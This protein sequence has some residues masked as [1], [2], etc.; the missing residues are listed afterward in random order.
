MNPFTI[1]HSGAGD[2]EQIREIYAEPS[3]FAATLQLPF[4]S[5]LLWEKR[6]STLVEGQFSLVAC[7]ADDVLGHLG[8]MVNANP[9]RRHVATLGMA[10]RTSARRQGVGSAILAAAIELAE[11]WHAVRRMELE[12]YTDN[13]A[14]IVMY[15]KSGFDIEGTLRQYAFRDGSLVDAHVMARIVA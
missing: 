2:F 13:E 4:P 8:L 9:R 10:V 7:R 3:N 15:Q 1:R 5:P 6:L 11:K 14:A 12:V